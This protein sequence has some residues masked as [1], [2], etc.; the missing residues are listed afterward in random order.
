M[1]MFGII[2]CP[3]VD[4]RMIELERKTLQAVVLLTPSSG[5][6]AGGGSSFFIEA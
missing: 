6:R 5:I 3:E 1:A 4:I 2:M